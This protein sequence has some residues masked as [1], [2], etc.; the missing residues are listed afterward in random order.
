MIKVEIKN[1]SHVKLALRREKERGV[2]AAK[3]ALFKES[4]R[5]KKLLRSELNA[6]AP[7][8]KPFAPLGPMA[9]SGRRS[10]AARKPLI[11]LAYMM[12]FYVFRKNQVWHARLG[13]VPKTGAPGG[14]KDSR[15]SWEKIL[16]AQAKGFSLD[17]TPAMRRKF[18]RMAMPSFGRWTSHGR[19]NAMTWSYK[20]RRAGSW[21]KAGRSGGKMFVARA[22][23]KSP[24][25]VRRDTKLRIPARPVIVPFWEARK[26]QAM[27]NIKRNFKR[28]M[29]DRVLNQ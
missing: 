13:Y 27:Q 19:G 26:A 21:Q 9:L 28:A 8:G 22:K 3:D 23:S 17:V 15:I 14:P 16:E 5:L 18:V 4:L 12:R 11:R 20:K 24:F 7:G 6:G 2:D 25:F 10:A 1:P 29:R